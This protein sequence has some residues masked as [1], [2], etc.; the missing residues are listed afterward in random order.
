[1]GAWLPVRVVMMGA[2]VS[3]R[4]AQPQAGMTVVNVGE[5]RCGIVVVGPAP[6]LQRTADRATVLER[7]LVERLGR[8]SSDFVVHVP[9]RCDETERA[10]AYQHTRKAARVS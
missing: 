2:P 10:A 6:R 3:V 4:A 7:V 9:Q 8:S 1:M 5:R